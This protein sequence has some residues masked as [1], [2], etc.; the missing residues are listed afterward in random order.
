MNAAGNE[1]GGGVR[2]PCGTV[3]HKPGCMRGGLRVQG[4]HP[5]PRPSHRAGGHGQRQAPQVP[6][7]PPAREV[8]KCVRGGWQLCMPMLDEE[9]PCFWASSP[10]HTVTQ[11]CTHNHRGDTRSRA[12]APWASPSPLPASPPPLHPLPRRG[13][14]HRGR[15]AAHC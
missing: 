13:A 4:S 6:A 14:A 7:Q 15:A 8:L 5:C 1:L 10:R 2:A 12:S 3:Q 11:P 9:V